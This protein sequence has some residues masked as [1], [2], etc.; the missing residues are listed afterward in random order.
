MQSYMKV[1]SR[2]VARWMA[3]VALAMLPWLVGCN[4][5]PN[6]TDVTRVKDEFLHLRFQSQIQPELKGLSDGRLFQMACKRNNVQCDLVIEKL[7]E[8]DPEFYKV[9]EPELKRN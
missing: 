4:A 8:S 7:K 9:L 3:V 5:E 6:A 1:N 2:P